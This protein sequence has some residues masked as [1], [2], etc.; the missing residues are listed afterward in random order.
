MIIT[1]R[2]SGSHSF[3]SVVC[4]TSERWRRMLC[5][6]REEDTA[7]EFFP[8]PGDDSVMPSF[9]SVARSWFGDRGEF[10][11]AGV[12]TADRAEARKIPTT[13]SPSC[14]VLLVD[15]CDDFL[16]GLNRLVGSLPG[17]VVV[18]TATSGAE[19]LELSDSLHPDLVLVDLAMPWMNGLQVARCLVARPQPPQIIIM[20]ADDAEAY[21]LAAVEAGA[22]SCLSKANL[23][24]D[25]EPSIKRLFAGILA[26]RP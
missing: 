7:R 10:R 3:P 25:L 21:E 11:P 12:R 8:K 23:S 4:Q 19:A 15:D 13:P 18:G 9:A 1:E 20:T 24:R 17:V 2:A 14:R 16:G 5:S 6:P 26:D 22:R